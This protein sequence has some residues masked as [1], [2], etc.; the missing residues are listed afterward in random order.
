MDEANK[1]PETTDVIPFEPKEAPAAPPAEPK[2]AAPAAEPEKKPKAEE[3][4]YYTLLAKPPKKK[5]KEDVAA[6]KKIAS[7]YLGIQ[8]LEKIV[9]NKKAKKQKKELAQRFKTPETP[10]E[11]YE[12]GQK[13]VN[14]AEC[15]VP[16][17]ERALYCRKAAE[18]FTGAGD[19]LDAPE[20][21]RT[22]DN[23]AREVEEDGFEQG[24]AAA[25]ERKQQAQ[26]NDEWFEAARAFERIAGYRDA[27]AQGAE[28][29]RVLDRRAG[30]RKP[31]LLLRVLVIFGLI[32]G[33]V[34]LSRTDRFQYQFARLAHR[35]GVDSVAAAFLSND[36][37]YADTDA[38]LE[39]I[40]YGEAEEYMSKG[41]YK[42]ALNALNKCTEFHSDLQARKDECNYALGEEYFADGHNKIA[43]DYYK[44]CSPGYKNRDARIDECNYNQAL[45]SL[46]H[47]DPAEALSHFNSA[48]GFADTAQQR[49]EPELELLE[50][51]Q[52]GEHVYFGAGEYVLLS[53]KGSTLTLLSATLTPDLTYH[54]RR[55]P[56]NWADCT[57]RSTLNSQTYLDEQFSPEEQA[58]LQEMDTGKSTDLVTV[59]SREEF[60]RYRTVMGGKDA[61]W[62]LRDNG[63]SRDSAMF[64][65]D[66]GDVMDA[67]YPVD[68]AEIHAR[69]MI[70]VALPA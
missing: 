39:E 15:A 7:R 67:G 69:T 60:L 27:D 57:L 64:V 12:R 51:A 11:F 48:N 9:N 44:E 29:Q 20:L 62:W 16:F 40:Y 45:F 59:P 70:R 37:E 31:M 2:S 56:V 58:L 32:V 34:I 17:Q 61:L 43:K 66:K 63:D 35:M 50:Q 28:C 13:Y 68:S 10:E 18:M 23:L 21:A 54:V 4:E 38:L 5:S 41:Q 52:V 36:N 47:G 55:E 19:Y 6:A 46:E 3:P 42:K 33:F 1:T 14:G 22:Y 26:T 65:S 30:M 8:A 25:M 53:R 24:Y 49:Y